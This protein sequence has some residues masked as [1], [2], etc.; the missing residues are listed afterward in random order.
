MP[1]GLE[2]DREDNIWVSDVGL[3][4]VIKFDPLGNQ[5]MIIGEKNKPGSDENHFNLPTDIA[6]AKD[7]SFYVSDG[8]GNSRIIKFSKNGDYLFE[9]GYMEIVKVNLIFH[10]PWI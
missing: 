7:G 6:V 9:W 3:H 5:V 4:Q 8:Y 1:H 2:V 10:M